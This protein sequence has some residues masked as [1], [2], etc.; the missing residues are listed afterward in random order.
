M[1]PDLPT[2]SIGLVAYARLTAD[3]LEECPPGSATGLVELSTGV[4]DLLVVNLRYAASQQE[5][6]APTPTYPARTLAVYSGEGERLAT[7]HVY[8]HRPD[9]MKDEHARTIAKHDGYGWCL[10]GWLLDSEGPLT[11]RWEEGEE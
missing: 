7:G 3:L 10:T 5:S 6:N 9:V 4:R 1:N 8:P 2:P 11:L